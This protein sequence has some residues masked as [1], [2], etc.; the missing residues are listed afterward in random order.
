[1]ARID[2]FVCHVTEDRTVASDLVLELETRGLKCWFAPRDIEGGRPYDDAIADALDD[3]R[4]MLLVF[5][6]RCNDS[7]YIRRE[8]T[9]A[10]ENGKPVI[11]LRIEDAKPR[12]GLKVRL[13]DLHWIDAFVERDRALDQL[14]EAVGHISADTSDSS[15]ASGRSDGDRPARPTSRE[16]GKVAEPSSTPPVV[17]T[18]SVAPTRSRRVGRAMVI[19]LAAAGA[20][21]GATWIASPF[22]PA[23]SRLIALFADRSPSHDI[24]PVTGLH[25]EEATP[26]TS[27]QPKRITAEEPTF[28]DP[29]TGKAAVWFFRTP[30]G[31]I[32]L[33][34]AK[35]YHPGTGEALS[36]V[37]REVVEEWKGRKKPVATRPSRPPKP[38][39]P[40]NYAFF[41]P[42]SGEPRIWYSRT[43]GG[44]FEFFDGPGFHPITGKALTS[45]DKTFVSEYQL[46]LEE[47]ERQ[48]IAAQ[49]AEANR[50]RMEAE[51]K[52]Q[53]EREEAARRAVEAQ[54]LAED[55][56]RQ[57]EQAEQERRARAEQEERQRRRDLEQKE[58]ERTAGDRCDQ[59]AGNPN[60]R[61]RNGDGVPYELLKLQAR[62][63][64]DACAKAVSVNPGEIRY[65]Y[66]LARATQMI[67]R[68]K[69]FELLKKV[70][71]RRY[72]AAFDNLGWLYMTVGKNRDEAVR[73]FRLGEQLGDPDSMVSLAEM[74]DQQGYLPADPLGE[75][76]RLYR[77]AAE[78]GHPAAQRALEI[79]MQ[80]FQ[81]RQQQLQTQ[82]QIQQQMLGI[83]GAALIGAMNHH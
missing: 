81:Q 66:Q 3:C 69:A 52:N 23:P 24:P 65:Q 67:D 33:Y 40:K 16:I 17:P 5:S 25:V 72:P 31:E 79:E 83:F 62:D 56:R 42:V 18:R 60:D 28:F 39:D 29:T 55:Q 22:D 74:I 32:E 54:R 13:A 61:R 51:A 36:P 53:R 19:A 64:I 47:E 76:I 59:L 70:A 37:T 38:V 35:G 14:V 73:Q 4:A 43:S 46:R 2:L 27:N 15:S 75:K 41:D 44:T 78:L 34:D 45:A 49:K 57:A 58:A 63:A 26:S 11:P 82:Q 9:V 21:A 20:V 1:M 48:R 77:A 7:D 50:L 8:V 80:N 12:K 10:G 30:A 68:T 71:T 6:D